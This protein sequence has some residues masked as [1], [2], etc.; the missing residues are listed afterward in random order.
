MPTSSMIYKFKS[1]KAALSALP[2]DVRCILM[3]GG[4]I[5]N[6]LTTL[7]R[8]LLFSMKAWNDPIEDIYASVQY[9]TLIGLLVGKVAEGLEVFQS[10]ILGKPF[11]RTYLPLVENVTGGREA[12]SSL[13]RMVGAKGL[14]RRLRNQ[15]TFH[16]PSDEVLGAA[17][18]SLSESE[19]WSMLAGHSRHT[20]LFPMSYFVTAQAQITATGKADIKEAIELIR[21][22]VLDGADALISFFERLTIAAADVQALF[23]GRPTPVKDTANL[24]DA[25]E[26]KIPPICKDIGWGS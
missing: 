14:L 24:P 26:V 17:F 3:L 16:N 7:H 10:R 9:S 19:D 25:V 5:V 20:V 15:H 22:E 1:T 8:L 12:V 21:D 6:E 4:H 11:G 23:V 2:D 18:A 13:R